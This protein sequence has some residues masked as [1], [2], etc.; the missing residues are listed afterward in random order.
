VIINIKSS[1]YLSE[2]ETGKTYRG[3]EQIEEKERQR[4]KGLVRERSRV[5]GERKVAWVILTIGL[6]STPE[7]F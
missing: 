1:E 3:I 5:G 6:R 2:I 7:N 4:A